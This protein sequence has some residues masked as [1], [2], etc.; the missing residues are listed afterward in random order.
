MTGEI[1]QFPLES[2]S[3]VCRGIRHLQWAVAQEVAIKDAI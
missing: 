1:V 2:A 3:P